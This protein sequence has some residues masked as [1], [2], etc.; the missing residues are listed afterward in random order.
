VEIQPRP[1]F[2]VLLVGIFVAGLAIRRIFGPG[3]G[4]AILIVGG[5]VVTA[6][7]IEG[8]EHFFRRTP[9]TPGG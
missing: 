3:W 9:P 5:L 2:W 8:D 4:V 7:T 1:A 6:L